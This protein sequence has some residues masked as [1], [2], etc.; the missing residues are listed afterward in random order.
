MSKQLTNNYVYSMLIVML[1]LTGSKTVSEMP[2]TP[3]TLKTSFKPTESNVIYKDFVSFFVSGVVSIRRF[4]R[5]K[6]HTRYYST[7][8]TVS[9]EAFAVLTI[10]NNWKWWGSMAER[11]E[12]KDSDVS[13]MYTTS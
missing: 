13:S 5:H 2:V 8:V 7:Y 10:E 6:L 1:S 4:D 12:W 11:E 9:N 3:E